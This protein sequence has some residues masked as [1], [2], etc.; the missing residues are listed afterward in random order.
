MEEKLLEILDKYDEQIRDY[1]VRAEALESK[2]TFCIEHN[3][4]EEKRIARIEFDVISGLIHKWRNMYNEVNELL[5]LWM[6]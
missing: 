6:S 5:N 3:F 1:E 4:F 2:I